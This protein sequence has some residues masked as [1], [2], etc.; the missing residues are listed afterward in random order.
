MMPM[1]PPGDMGLIPQGNH[2]Q[3]LFACVCGALFLI[4]AFSGINCAWAGEARPTG[5]EVRF[6]IEMREVT[7]TKEYK[8]ESSFLI[9][10]QDTRIFEVPVSNGS[11][12]LVA[13]RV[14]G[15][16][17]N[18]AMKPIHEKDA[19]AT[20]ERVLAAHLKAGKSFSRGLEI[21][22]TPAVYDDAPI[23]D[24]KDPSRLGRFVEIDVYRANYTLSIVV[25]YPQEVMTVDQAFDLLSTA[26][27]NMAA[28]DAMMAETN[29]VMTQAVEGAK[30]NTNIGKFEFQDAT[31]P[32]LVNAKISEGQE[33]TKM[34]MV[35]R[36][37]RRTFWTAQTGV[38]SFAC[39]PW[40]ADT[41]G[42]ESFES[43]LRKASDVSDFKAMPDGKVGGLEIRRFDYMQSTKGMKIPVATWQVNGRENMMLVTLLGKTNDGF[44]D[45][46]GASLAGNAGK[47]GLIPGSTPI[48]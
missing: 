10:G 31:V 41:K 47:C 33:G 26:N 38:A 46:L 19:A 35:Y 8:R 1:S 20:R 7:R 37:D 16:T 34:T 48:P 24:A 6:P 43:G 27:Y 36:V 42:S 29:A 14:A 21:G 45:Q 12:I 28:L 22:G 44:R 13:T 17:A 30:A 4:L 15:I 32:E 5:L 9:S 25:V 3:R 11:R 40:I 23:T 39:Y 2:M 18:G